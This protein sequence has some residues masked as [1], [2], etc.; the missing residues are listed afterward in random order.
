MTFQAPGAGQ[1]KPGTH[2]RHCKGGLYVVVGTCL[3]EATLKTG[4]LYQ[5]LQGEM[6]HVTW[7]RPSGD[8]RHRGRE[9]APVRDPR[10]RLKRGLS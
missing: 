3:I 4:V 1:L 2:L 6:Q 10:S 7:M 5:P 9:S 8:G